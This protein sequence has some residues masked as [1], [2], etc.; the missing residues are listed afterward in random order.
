MGD[1]LAEQGGFYL[2]VQYRLKNGEIVPADVE[3]LDYTKCRIKKEDDEDNS[4]NIIYKDFESKKRGKDDKLEFFPWTA[5]KEVLTAQIM[6]AGKTLEDA[7]RNFK[8]N[9]MFVNPTNMVYPLS[10]FDA[11]YN[12]MDSEYR[13]SLYTNS[14]TRTGFLGKTSVLI[15]G[16]DED[17]E[18]QVKKDIQNWLG[19]EN[20]ASVYFMPVDTTEDLDNVL[21]V[22]TVASQYDDKMFEK[23]EARIRKNILGAANNIPEALVFASSGSLFGTSGEA[24]KEMK[25]FYSEQTDGERKLVQG[26]LNSLGYNI[27]LD[28]L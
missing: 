2:L 24:Y 21:K 7:I 5:D 25:E 6:T 4:G 18:E 27:I 19:A 28:P 1:D 15:N 20:S 13:I 14:M 3:V 12:E 8:G 16:L 26:V 23:T 22:S 10:P 11:V 17:Q 9:V